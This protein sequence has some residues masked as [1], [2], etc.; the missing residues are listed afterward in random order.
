VRRWVVVLYGVVAFASAALASDIAGQASV[1]D[2]DTLDIH[3]QRIRI[4]DIDAPEHNQLCDDANGAHY[5]CGGMAANQLA[6]FIGQRPVICSPLYNDRWGRAV[7]FCSV[8]GQDLGEW[9]VKNGMAIRWP[10]YDRLG[11]YINA[12]VNAQSAKIGLWG[13]SFLEPWDFRTC[14]RGHV[15]SRVCSDLHP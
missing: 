10:K 7:A 14:V 3:G 13:G 9:L 4:A 11:R 6:H 12:Q 5:M 8:E 15:R 1:V 2:G